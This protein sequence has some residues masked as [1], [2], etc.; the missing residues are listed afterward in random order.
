MVVAERQHTELLLEA[1]ATG[2]L[3]S[4]KAPA[5]ATPVAEGIDDALEVVVGRVD[6]T[7]LA[8][9]DVVRRIKAA[10]RDVS[11][12]ASLAGAPGDLARVL[13]AE[14]VAVVLDHP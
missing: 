12:R 7:A 9:G 11:E 1:H 14:R 3:L 10:G 4:G 13:G 8:R 6:R 2:V 5:V